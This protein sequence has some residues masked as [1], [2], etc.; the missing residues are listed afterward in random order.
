V[1]KV[2]LNDVTC[3]G[4]FLISRRPWRLESSAEGR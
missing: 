3:T 1:L 4:D 2:S